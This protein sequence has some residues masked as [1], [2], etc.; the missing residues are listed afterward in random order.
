[1][2]SPVDILGSETLE[3]VTFSDIRSVE[4]GGYW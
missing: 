1:M 4:P 2:S 3:T